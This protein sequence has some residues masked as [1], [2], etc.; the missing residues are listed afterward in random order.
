VCVTFEKIK[1]SFLLF[2]FLVF[3]MCSLFLAL[4]KLYLSKHTVKILHVLFVAR[5]YIKYVY[6][7]RIPTIVIIIIT[8][9]IILLLLYFY[10]GDYLIILYL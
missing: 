3:K 1:M 7:R 6:I 2:F 5:F 9:I 8:I 10:I 4:I